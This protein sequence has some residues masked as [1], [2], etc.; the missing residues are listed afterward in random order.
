M[1]RAAVVDVAEAEGTDPNGGEAA[2]TSD[3]SARNDRDDA[4]P[5]WAY[6]VALRERRRRWRRAV[7]V[8]D[9]VR[10][11]VPVL[12]LA[13]SLPLMLMSLGPV[14][15]ALQP[16][17]T[18]TDTGLWEA[19]SPL[20]PTFGVFAGALAVTMFL[21]LVQARLGPTPPGSLRIDGD[22]EQARIVR[23]ARA[24]AIAARAALGRLQGD[25]LRDR[26]RPHVDT[27]DATT[28][29][30]AKVM[31]EPGLAGELDQRAEAVTATADEL[32]RLV[33]A[34]A[35]MQPEAVEQLQPDPATLLTVNDVLL[36][37]AEVEVR[38]FVRAMHALGGV[39]A[40]DIAPGGYRES[41]P[42]ATE[43]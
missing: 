31:H 38:A 4:S 34:E 12:G 32:E 40:A 15:K 18:E 17:F 16:T 22:D 6:D 21:S 25:E 35:A 11:A 37:A 8:V 30:M 39:A 29:A 42:P 1:T 3:R 24:A 27:L 7:A 19:L 5:L 2:T 9:A 43:G 28:W 33:V 20:V 14:V 36:G 10:W 13:V 26:L 23:R 41:H